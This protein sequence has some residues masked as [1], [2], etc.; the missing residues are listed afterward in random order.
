MIV[1]LICD[2]GQRYF[3]TELCGMPKHVEIPER[4]H[5]MDP[6]TTAA[7]R[8][9]PDEVGDHR[10]NQRLDSESWQAVGRWLWPRRVVRLV[11]RGLSWPERSRRQP[12]RRRR[13]SAYAE[14][15]GGP[16]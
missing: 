6:Y 13:P 14:R 15:F 12:R 10:L 4:D 3:S 16:P 2:T 5:P 8:Q 7:A 11:G 9:V 1:T